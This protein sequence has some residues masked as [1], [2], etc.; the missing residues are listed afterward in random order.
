MAFFKIDT[1]KAETQASRL[2]EYG[3]FVASE[4]S[5]IY[6]SSENNSHPVG[7]VEEAARAY[8]A[9]PGAS[10]G[11]SGPSSPDGSSTQPDA[12]GGDG[13]STT[14]AGCASAIVGLAIELN[15]RTT[16]VINLNSNGVN[17]MNSDGT[18]SYYLPDPPEG[19]VDEA[20]YWASM[21]TASNVRAYNSES[22]ANGKKQAQE[23]QAAINS[24]DAEKAETIRAE[25]EKH[26]DVPA[27]GA[28]FVSS[29]GGARDYLNLVNTTNQTFARDPNKIQLM[30]DTLGHLLAGASQ[31]S[32]GGEPLGKEFGAEIYASKSPDDVAAFNALVTTTGT[33][34]GSGF[35]LNAADVLEEVDPK[36]ISSGT[37]YLTTEYSTD[38]LA[39]VLELMAKD[40]DLSLAYLGGNGTVDEGGNWQPDGNTAHRWEKLT[41]REWGAIPAVN[42]SKRKS[43]PAIDSFTAAL[44]QAASFRNPDAEHPDAKNDARAT[45]AAAKGMKYFASD[46]WP[47]DKFSEAMQKNMAVVVANS[48]E[49]LAAASSG[50]W[51]EGFGAGPD[52]ATM[53]VDAKDI[54]TL[55]YRFGNNSDAM[56]TV[57]VAAGKY[58]GKRIEAA[59]SAVNNGVGLED[60]YSRYRQGAETSAYLEGLSNMRFNDD[61][62]EKKDDAAK[63]EAKRNQTV[64]TTMAVA[65]TMIG[66]GVSAASAGTAGPAAYAV[67]SN[68]TQPLATDFVLSLLGSPEVGDANS[69]DNAYNRRKA[70]GYAVALNHGWLTGED[71]KPSAE[72]NETGWYR[73]DA[74]GNPIVDVNS[75]NDGQIGEMLDWG[76][77][78]S[79]DEES[80]GSDKDGK[81]D[82]ADTDNKQKPLNEIDQAVSGG[83]T[84]GGQ[85]INNGNA[86]AA[87]RRN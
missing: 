64:G 24:G 56:S 45:Y 29:V 71:S 85:Q 84:D 79:D 10:G 34:F 49:E 26:Q 13:S 60:F 65:N 27:Y 40:K 57:S 69:A 58:H 68:I 33:K 7:T 73:E 42:F 52:L 11:T 20:A 53:G 8:G 35:I 39:G 66:L 59:A 80:G 77:G 70:Q 55:I 44:A 87:P 6:K 72:D 62:K 46:K 38:P 25:I 63:I 74:N 47:K 67:A 37:T 3:T 61:I 1:E 28:T 75:L 36:T 19:T 32:V 2:N 30:T 51:H 78:G 16:E 83:Q 76:A 41:T 31:P 12:L 23:F 21:D 17:N 48:P 5:N 50:R 43:P 54:S 22:A 14:L 82:G 4:R 18:Y 86:A 9:V 81:N 15:V